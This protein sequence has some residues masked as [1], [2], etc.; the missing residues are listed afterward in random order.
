MINLTICF[1]KLHCIS[2]LNNSTSLIIDADMRKKVLSVANVDNQSS[3]NERKQRVKMRK[4][5]R[6][7]QQNEC[8][9]IPKSSFPHFSEL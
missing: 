8:L 5:K 7:E 6:I 1:N 4:D 2:N 3:D 9:S